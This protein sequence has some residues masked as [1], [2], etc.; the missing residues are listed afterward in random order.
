[1]RPL[2]PAALFLSLVAGGWRGDGSGVASGIDLAPQPTPKWIA[3]LAHPGNASPVRFGPWV[4]VTEEPAS[5][6]CFNARTG[7]LGWSAQTDLADGRP[8]G[9]Q[10][11]VRASIAAIQAL[12]IELADLRSSYGQLLR[13]LRAA[14][15]DDV[16]RRVT[17]LTERTTAIRDQLGALNDLRLPPPDPIVGWMT[18]TPVTDG[19]HLWVYH[20]FGMVS[21][22]DDQGERRWTR[23][24]GRPASHRRGEDS[25]PVGQEGVPTASPWLVDGVLVVPHD[26][27][28]GLNPATGDTLWTAGPYADFGTGA[29][30]SI[31]ASHLIA[32]PDGHLIDT[33]DGRSVAQDLG[34][35]WYVGPYVVG[36]RLYFIGSSSDKNTE[37]TNRAVAW[38]VE[39]DHEGVQ[40][41]QL[42]DV[43]LPTHERFYASPV[44]HQSRLVAVTRRGTLVSLHPDT[45]DARIAHI[46]LPPGSEVWPSPGSVDGAL[47]V[48]T[49]RGALLQV[50]PSTGDA[51]PILSVGAMLS[52]PLVVEGTLYLRTHDALIAF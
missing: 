33:T 12:E 16:R 31:G 19:H 40:L 22:F 34:T 9:E 49:D 4:C 44:L 13:E 39:S 35:V 3:P 38:Q 25:G 42:W 5:V 28:T 41:T 29:M 23:D 36:H 45:G 24:L 50:N 46:S 20:A 48:P 1:M 6:R 10:A 37:D 32:T 18:P 26:H 11:T 51:S 15:S 27:L 2:I 47:W 30:L 8:E 14:P 17:E 52:T 7:A 21:C 43:G